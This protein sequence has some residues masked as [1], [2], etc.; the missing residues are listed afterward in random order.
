M[1]VLPAVGC[2]RDVLSVPFFF[3]TIT[4][5]H[6][7]PSTGALDALNTT[8]VLTLETLETVRR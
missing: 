5:L 8:K 2:A 6:I 3:K 1:R 7:T 4:Q